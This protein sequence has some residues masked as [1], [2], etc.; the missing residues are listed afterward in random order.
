MAV[1]INVYMQI[2]GINT[3]TLMSGTMMTTVQPGLALYSNLI[4]NSTRL[5]PALFSTFYVGKKWGRRPLYL[6]SGVILAICNYLVAVGYIANS[7]GLIIFALYAYMFI[8][9]LM[10]TPLNYAYPAEITPAPKVTIANIFNMSAMTISL[11]LPPIVIE[12]MNGD[13]YPVFLFFGI[14][15]T[16]SLIYMYNSLVESKGLKYEDIIKAF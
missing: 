3:I 10:V 1:H 4:L 12:A 14:Y 5:P 7:T 8:F 15:I 16:V 6:V 11:L 9:S 13:A 2:M